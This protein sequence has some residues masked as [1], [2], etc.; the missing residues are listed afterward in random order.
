LVDK[1]LISYVSESKQEVNLAADQHAVLI[2]D[3][4]YG[5]RNELAMER[6]KNRAWYSFST[7]YAEET[8]K[9]LQ[10]K[11]YNVNSNWSNLYTSY[12]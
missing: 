7:W 12:G 8:N 1:I 11:D 5:H 4:W 10:D 9:H 3:V 2:W 6:C